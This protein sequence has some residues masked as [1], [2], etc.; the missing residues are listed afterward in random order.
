MQ[1]SAS[2]VKQAILK[3]KWKGKTPPEWG[4]KDIPYSLLQRKNRNINEYHFYSSETDYTVKEAE[5]IIAALEETDS[6][7]PVKIFHANCRIDSII[8]YDSLEKIPEAGG[9]SEDKVDTQGNDTEE[10]NTETQAEASEGEA[11]SQDDA[12]TNADS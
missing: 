6:N 11:A 3:K 5:T 4:F 12:Q 8:P 9:K 10:N 7:D 1:L 2:E